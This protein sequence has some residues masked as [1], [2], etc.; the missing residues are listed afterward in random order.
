MPTDLGRA[1]TFLLALVPVAACSTLDPY[2]EVPNER[3]GYEHRPSLFSFD[4]VPGSSDAS[5]VP[6]TIAQVRRYARALHDAYVDAVSDQETLNN[7]AQLS[8]IPIAATAAGLGISGGSSDAIT[9]LG[10]SGAGLVTAGT[11]AV[12]EERQRIYLAGARAMTCIQRL[13]TDYEAA[14]P[15]ADASAAELDQAISE[16]EDARGNL[17]MARADVQ[18]ILDQNRNLP[19]VDD[20]VDD[21]DDINIVSRETLTTAIHLRSFV[22]IPAQTLLDH[23]DEIQD[24]VNRLIQGTSVDLTTFAST[25]PSRLD[26]LRT[27]TTSPD[28]TAS[29]D[30]FSAM[31]AGLDTAS[32][33]GIENLRVKLEA[34]RSANDDLVHLINSLIDDLDSEIE[35]RIPDRSCLTDFPN[36]PSP[37]TVSPRPSV[38]ITGPAEAVPFDANIVVSGGVPPYGIISSSNVTIERRIPMGG[39]RERFDLSFNESASFAP[40]VIYDGNDQQDQ[41]EVPVNRR[42]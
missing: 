35:L 30:D 33:R 23:I 20:L 36:A 17:E 18:A 38:G 31:T 29:Q 28:P 3:P 27:V 37:L 14:A 21:L 26:A 25:L 41:I 40:I 32:S 16:L 22:R 5:P 24:V 19:A 2:I 8:L 13:A 1:V 12:N 10:L 9:I 39:A 4:G 6:T 42:N 15:F 34:V 11:V 7:T